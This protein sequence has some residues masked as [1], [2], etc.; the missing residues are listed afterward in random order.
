[1][2]NEASWM[3]CRWT[4]K[5]KNSLTFLCKRIIILCSG[6]K[7]YEVLYLWI[8]SMINFVWYC[9]HD[10]I[11]SRWWNESS[12]LHVPVPVN[13]YFHML[14]YVVDVVKYSRCSDAKWGGLCVSPHLNLSSSVATQRLGGSLRESSVKKMKRLLSDWSVGFLCGSTKTFEPKRRIVEN[15]LRPD[16]D[17]QYLHTYQ[18]MWT[19][20]CFCCV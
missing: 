7:H 8:F 15:V 2:V 4:S 10:F 17:S 18:D 3:P 20:T 12:K 14:N 13:Y 19:Q 9:V 16:V 6:V 1:M 5:L 11:H